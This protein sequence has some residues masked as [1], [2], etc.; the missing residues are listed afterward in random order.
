[1]YIYIDSSNTSYSI[2][3]QQIIFGENSVSE[4][5]TGGLG[6]NPSATSPCLYDL[7]KLYCLSHIFFLYHKIN[8]LARLSWKIMKTYD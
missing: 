7:S 5:D 8:M 4:L 6:Q 2:I 1:M 3:S